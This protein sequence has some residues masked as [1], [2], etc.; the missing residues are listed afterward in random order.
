M[1]R[2]KE[3]WILTAFQT[4]QKADQ[5]IIYP[6]QAPHQVP[7]SPRIIHPPQASYQVPGSLKII[8]PPQAPLPMKFSF[9]STVHVLSS[10]IVYWDC[11]PSRKATDLQDAGSEE[12]GV[13][14]VGGRSQTVLQSVPRGR[15]RSV[16]KSRKMLL[17]RINAIND[18]MRRSCESWRGKHDVFW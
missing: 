18:V 2:V 7:G 12:V 6:S 13:S 8:H 3:L 17:F 14:A 9:S 4:F 16:R 11:R 1:S 10:H 5:E 15:S